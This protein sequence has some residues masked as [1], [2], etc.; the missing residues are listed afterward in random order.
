MFKM[1]NAV[2]APKSRSVNAAASQACTSNPL[3][4][5][6]FLLKVIPDLIFI[7]AVARSCTHAQK[8]HVSRCA[9]CT[10]H[11]FINYHYLLL[12]AIGIHSWPLARHFSHVIRL[13]RRRRHCAVNYKSNTRGGNFRGRRSREVCVITRTLNDLLPLLQ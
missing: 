9:V 5:I 1:H 7:E 13:A 3:L 12:A 2:A 6:A 11:N 4:P 10:P 8:R